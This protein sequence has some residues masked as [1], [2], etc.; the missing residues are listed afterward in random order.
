[1]ANRPSIRGSGMRTRFRSMSAAMRPQINLAA[2]FLLAAI[3]LHVP[4]TW[5]QTIFGRISGSVTDPSG[6]AVVGAKVTITGA[7]TQSVRIAT[8]DGAGFYAVTN[9]S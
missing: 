3:I 7:E 6:A 8:T 9:L 5:G 4:T 2:F 1:M